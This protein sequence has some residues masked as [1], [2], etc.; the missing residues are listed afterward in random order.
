M[1]NAR[2]VTKVQWES[3][4]NVLERLNLIKALAMTVSCYSEHNIKLLV[5]VFL[6]DCGIRNCIL[7]NKI[8]RKCKRCEEGYREN[9]GECVG[10]C[11]V[12]F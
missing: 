10:K 5:T 4:P 9:N 7:C 3:V 11:V 12:F 8:D 1:N 2:L 6:T